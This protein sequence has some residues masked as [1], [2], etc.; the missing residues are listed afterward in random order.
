MAAFTLPQRAFGA[1]C[2]VVSFMILIFPEL[3]STVITTLTLGFVSLEDIR[4]DLLASHY[5][6]VCG[7]FYGYIGFWYIANAKSEEFSRF[8]VTGRCVGVPIGFALLVV[9]GKVPWKLMVFVVMDVVFALWT[10]ASFPQKKA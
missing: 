10:Q 8:S 7:F 3:F 5:G 6:S 9:L 2:A 1:Y 4:P